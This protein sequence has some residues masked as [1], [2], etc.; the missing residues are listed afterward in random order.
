MA[1]DKETFDQLLATIERFVRERLVPNE[2]R[3]ADDDAIPRDIADEMRELG[4]FGLSIPEAYGGIGLNMSEEVRV[5]F[6]LGQ[7]SPAFRSLFGT[8]V[9]IGSQGLVI[10]GTEE[11]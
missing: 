10:D 1:L 3:I 8:N 2:Q 7:T 11:Q 5:V 6:A 9:G 4:L